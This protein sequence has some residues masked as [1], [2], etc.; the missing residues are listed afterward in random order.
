MPE[1]PVFQTLPQRITGKRQCRTSKPCHSSLLDTSGS[2]SGSTREGVSDFSSFTVT[3]MRPSGQIST[4]AICPPPSTTP[5][6]ARLTSASVNLVFD[7]AGR[8]E[9]HPVRLTPA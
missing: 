9:L 4:L 8:V 6:T 2:F 7:I 3:D 1:P 5:L